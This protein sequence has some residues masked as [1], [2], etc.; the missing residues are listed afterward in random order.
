MKKEETYTIKSLSPRE[1]NVLEVALDHMYDHLTDLIKDQTTDMDIQEVT[2]I[3]TVTRRACIEKIQDKMYLDNP[4]VM[5]VTE[6]LKNKGY[7]HK[8]LENTKHWTETRRKAHA[9]DY[10]YNEDFLITAM[11]WGETPEGHDFWS[12]LSNEYKEVLYTAEAKN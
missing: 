3:E 9:K 12:A 4:K 11:F 2:L 10:D 1:F 6:F 5:S 8:L 7:W